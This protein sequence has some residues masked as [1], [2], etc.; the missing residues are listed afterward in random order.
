[1]KSVDEDIKLAEIDVTKMKI[2]LNRKHFMDSM[3]N[4]FAFQMLNRLGNT[5]ANEI[6][7]KNT[8]NTKKPTPKSA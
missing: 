5:K 6:L 3:L 4:N 7:E 8:A 1:V 2:S